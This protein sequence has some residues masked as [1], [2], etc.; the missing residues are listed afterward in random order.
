MVVSR[1]VLSRFKY[2]NIILTDQT[3]NHIKNAR[4]LVKFARLKIG[5]YG[6]KTGSG[7][8]NTK[9]LKPEVTSLSD[10]SVL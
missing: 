10:R 9:V 4:Y 5:S 3:Q 7:G 6:T 1:L 8:T 2:R